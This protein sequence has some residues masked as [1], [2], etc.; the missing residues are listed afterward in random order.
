M[1]KLLLIF[2]IGVLLIGSLL[3]LDNKDK[4]LNNFKDIQYDCDVLGPVFLLQNEMS[5]A[6]DISKK[7]KG[8]VVIP[9]ERG[10]KVMSETKLLNACP[11]LDLI[12]YARKMQ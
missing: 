11:N 8:L 2:G 9:G 7:T 5:S 6:S 3:I 1:N 4:E 10:N 12:K